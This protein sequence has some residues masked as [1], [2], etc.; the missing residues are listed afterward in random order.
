MKRY[1]LILLYLLPLVVSAQQVQLGADRVDQIRAIVRDQRVGLI[2][3]QTSVLTNGTHL[4]DTLLS[5]DIKVVKIFAPEHGFRGNADAGETIKDGKDAQTSLPVISLY[6]KNYKPTPEQLEDIDFLIFDIQDVGTRFYTYIS[7]MH[8]AMEAC[9]ENGKKMLVLDRPNPNDCIN[10]PVLD[11]KYKSFVGVHPI[12]VLHGLTVAELAKMIEGESWLKD[13][14]QCEI[15][16]L[17]MLG[18]RHGQPYSL[19][20][21]PSPN[22]PNDHAIALYPSLCFFEATKISVGRGTDFP[23][24]VIGAPGSKY[25]KF[26]FTPKPTEGAKSPMHKGLTCYGEDLR[27]WETDGDL[28]LQFLLRMYKKSGKGAA[29]FSSPKF[30]DLLA[31]SDKLRKQIIAGKPEKEIVDSW[32]ADLS[33][34][35]EIRKKYLLYPDY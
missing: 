8:Y 30:M 24:E 34:Y 6:G 33:A 22:L 3:N 14:L 4:L 15:Y 32:Q 23:F 27:E 18:W 2:V 11:T 25:G 26:T 16:V 12:P 29:F 35:K 17:P 10:G 9:A 7:T 28:D 5:S 31:G 21:K 13:N 20:V 1:I 19:P